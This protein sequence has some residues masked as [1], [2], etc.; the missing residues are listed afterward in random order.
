MTLVL[1]TEGLGKRYR[2]TWALRD[3]DLAIPAGRVVALVG[4]N[5]AGKTTLL[6]MASGLLA[7]TAGRITVL[8]K[9]APADSPDALAHLG[10]VAQEHPLYRRFRVRE[11]LQM[12]GALNAGW[13]QD[14][15]V[16]RLGDL[17]IP[18]DRRAGKL[19]GGQHAQ[20]ALTLALA[21]RPRLLILDEPVASLDPL[22]RREFMQTLMRTVT[23][24]EL[25]V[26]LSSH[27][28][29]ELERVCDYLVVLAEGRVQLAGDIDDLLGEHRLLTGPASAVL[30][31]PGAIDM[32]GSDRYVNAVVRCQPAE[33]FPGLQAHPIGLEELVLA[34]LRRV[35][36]AAPTRPAPVEMSA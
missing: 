16:R 30:D 3:C 5:G 7:P 4:P 10:F 15:A 1:A 28:V 21:K 20:V 17:Q 22:A 19:S 26:M 31:R 36:S 35:H 11:L 9:D 29:G 24:D 8:G 14:L 34:Y 23:D 13:D 25:T 6:Q 32:T 18:L 33:I 27:N 12:C 2:S